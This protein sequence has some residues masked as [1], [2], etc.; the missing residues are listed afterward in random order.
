L[1]YP[2][3]SMADLSGVILSPRELPEIVLSPS[4]RLYLEPPDLPGGAP[5]V[6]RL[7]RL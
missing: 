2:L 1:I 6:R 7:C 3:G 4:G 5:R